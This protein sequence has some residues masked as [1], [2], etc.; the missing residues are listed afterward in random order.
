MHAQSLT[1]TGSNFS[2]SASYVIGGVTVSGDEYLDGDLIK[3]VS[4][5]AAFPLGGVRPRSRP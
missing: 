4:G 2:K 1:G 3:T 5:L